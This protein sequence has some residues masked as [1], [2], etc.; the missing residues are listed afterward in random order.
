METKSSNISNTLIELFRN[1]EYEICLSTYLDFINHKELLHMNCSQNRVINII[2]NSNI[3]MNSI[4]TH[5]TDL[6]NILCAKIKSYSKEWNL[7]TNQNDIQNKIAK[8]THAM[9]Q[10]AVCIANVK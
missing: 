1:K 6:K 4:N 2:K 9:D 10:E 7:I 8:V 3:G 5:Y